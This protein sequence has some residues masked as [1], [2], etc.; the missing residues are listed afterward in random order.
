MQSHALYDGD[1]VDVVLEELRDRIEAAMAA[2]IAPERLVVDPGLGFAKTA[3]HNWALLAG[4][5]RLM[6]LGHP[7]LVGSSRKSF[8]GALLAGPDGAP[9][10]VDDREDA[11]T[12]LTTLV[13]ARGVWGVRVHEV[14]A[15]LDAIRVVTR[16]GRE[17]GVRLR[18]E[19]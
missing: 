8:L 17:H 9:R 1:V 19:G 18:S 12:A 7:V 6:G 2:G 5:G 16:L 14:R 10:P 13:A 11:N 3:D 15:S 4:L